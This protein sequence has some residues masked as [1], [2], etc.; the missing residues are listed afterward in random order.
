M[1]YDEGNEVQCLAPSKSHGMRE[2]Q[3]SK[4]VRAPAR[5]RKLHGVDRVEY[6]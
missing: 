2:R 5:R 6:K 1:A 3:L 4:A